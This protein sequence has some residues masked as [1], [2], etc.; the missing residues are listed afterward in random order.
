MTEDHAII[1]AEVEAEL[2]LQRFEAASDA[3]EHPE[4]VDQLATEAHIALS[5]FEEM[6]L[7]DPRGY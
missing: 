4:L 3:D 2:A 5:R 6:R 7:L 1:A